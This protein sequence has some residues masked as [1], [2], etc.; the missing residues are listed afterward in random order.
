MTR[1]TTTDEHAVDAGPAQ[2]HRQP[3]PRRRTGVVRRVILATLVMLLVVGG[4]ATLSIE[5]SRRNESA[6]DAL[7]LPLQATA[8]TDARAFLQR[9]EASNGR[10][11]RK[12]QGGDTVSEGQGYA[13]LLAVAVGARQQ[14]AA[15]WHW[16]QTHLQLPDGL[17][18]YHWNEGK[19]VNDQP[20][21]DAD[22]QTA[23]ALVL[24]GQRFHSSL[25][26]SQGLRVSSA[27]MSDETLVVA[28]KLQLVAGPWGRSSPAVVDPSYFSLAAM[29]S[30]QRVSG[31]ARWSELATDS[32]AVVTS[33]TGSGHTLP[34]NW[35]D[36]GS[37]GSVEAIGDP[38]SSKSTPAYGLDAQRVPVWFAAGCT[39]GARAVAADAWPLLRRS[40]DQGARISYGVHGAAQS[41]DVNPL[42]WV[43][44]AASASAAGDQRASRELLAAA[45]RQSARFHTYYGDAWVALG[46]ILLD[47]AWLSPCAPGVGSS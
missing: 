19:V 7:T 18:A 22:L 13:M 9:Y 37:T 33:L 20:A 27:V 3:Q 35:V 15:A 45:D 12:D 14:F 5:G 44:A 38:S 36:V 47:T 32:T 42:G 10:V 24:A 34:P 4:I 8:R 26:L 2:Q 17:F 40:A 31:D 46:R 41:A 25:Y 11:V 29:D 28:G 6:P 39:Q 1:T 30:L 43:A 23:W 21:T 16:D